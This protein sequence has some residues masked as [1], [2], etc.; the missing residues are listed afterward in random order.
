MP[1]DSLYMSVLVDI[2]EQLRRS[3]WIALRP[4]VGL[5]VI[6]VDSGGATNGRDTWQVQ[7]GDWQKAQRRVIGQAMS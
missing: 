5:V 2:F 6:H 1:V 3:R 4:A 7:T